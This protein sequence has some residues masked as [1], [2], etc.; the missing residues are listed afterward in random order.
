M[1]VR[2]PIGL[3]GLLV[4]TVVIAGLTISMAASSVSA[5]GMSNRVSNRNA[6]HEHRYQAD[7]SETLHGICLCEYVGADHLVKRNDVEVTLDIE[8]DPP[9]RTQVNLNLAIK[10]QSSGRLN[11]K[12]L[13][14]VVRN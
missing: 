10:V 5:A 9:Y 14:L 12:C 11:R 7:C 8:G 3:R 13:D 1:A 2:L 6:S 4:V